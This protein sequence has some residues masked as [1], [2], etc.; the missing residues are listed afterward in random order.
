MLPGS[1]VPGCCSVSIRFLWAILSTSTV[2]HNWVPYTLTLNFARVHGRYG[3]WF[4]QIPTLSY[5]VQLWYDREDEGAKSSRTVFGQRHP[6]R[7]GQFQVTTALRRMLIRTSGC[8]SKTNWELCKYL[9][10]FFTSE[11]SSGSQ[12]P[13][14][15]RFEV[16]RR[17]GRYASWEHFVNYDI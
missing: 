5:H 12:W 6:K 16:R 2:Q 1:A 8:P 4:K 13:V 17:M 10:S 9:G 7:M 14:L 3:E 11:R 15:T